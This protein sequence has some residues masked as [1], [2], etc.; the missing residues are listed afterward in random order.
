MLLFRGNIALIRHHFV[1]RVQ[2]PKRLRVGVSQPFL[3]VNLVLNNQG[4]L[5][6]NKT[7]SANVITRNTYKT[8][9]SYKTII[10]DYSY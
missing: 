5:L 10:N 2:I 3:A 1:Q 9:M 4:F 7:N 6:L 8:L